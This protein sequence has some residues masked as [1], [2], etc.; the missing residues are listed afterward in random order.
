MKVGIDVGGTF[1]DGVVWDGDRIVSCKVPTQQ[2]QSGGVMAALDQLGA[3]AAELLHGTTVATNA[4][5]E[6]AGARTALICDAGFEDLLEIGRQDRPSLYDQTVVRPEPLVPG[7]HRIGA[8]RRDAAGEVDAAALVEALRATDAEAVAIVALY[9]YA[10]PRQE[11]AAAAAIHASLPSVEVSLSSQV[12]PEFR[13]FERM[14]TTVLDAY[15]RPVVAGYLRRL[16]KAVGDGGRV[17]RT[18]VMRSSGGL[19]GIRE[20]AALPVATLLSGPAAGVVAA[21]ALGD[22]VGASSVISFD[23]GGTSTDVCR[24]E[25]GRPEIAYE[26]AIDGLPCRMPSVAVHTVGAGGGSIAW[27]DAGG[28]LRVG[29]QSAGADPGPA[30]YGH[31]GADATVTDAN[32]LL[33]RLGSDTTL[34][35]SVALDASAAVEALERLGEASGLTAEEAALGVVAVVEAHMARAI[36]RVSV[37]EGADPRRSALVAFGG[38]G[39][40]HASALARTLEMERVLVPPYAG[41]FSALGLLLSAPRADA[42]LSRRVTPDGLDAAADEILRSARRALGG[43]PAVEDVIFDVRYR[44]QSHETPVPYEAGEGWERLVERFETIHRARN[45]FARPGDDVEVVTVRAEVAGTPAARWSD[46]PAPVPQ[47]EARR[48]SR[49]VATASGPLDTVIWWRPGLE[50][51]TEIPGPAVV[52][53]PSST[54]FIGTG[55]RAVVLGDGTLEITW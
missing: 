24:I 34:G 33:G 41:V 43:E 15:L 1:T 22:A 6:R 9:G 20:A 37:E 21:A 42:A 51:G 19:L 7:P 44:G 18:S 8:L 11:E 17:E 14:S 25:G 49:Q 5:L 53:D 38:A 4:V 45:G 52:E 27:V 48:G 54:T 29:P 32:L 23:M 13:E 35:G 47:G 10:D 28:A 36:R 12:A 46:L 50:L 40:L 39:G 31:G 55:E 3:T 30:A 16:Q 26:R 2:D